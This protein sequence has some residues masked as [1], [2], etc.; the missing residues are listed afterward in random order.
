[1]HPTVRTILDAQ[2]GVASTSQ[3]QAAG[4]SRFEVRR[5]VQCGGLVRLRRGVVV[6]T[7]VWRAAASWDKHLIRARGL[8]LGP[9]G[10][11]DSPVALSHQSVLALHDIAVHGVDD[12]VHV[13]RIDGRRGQSDAFVQCHAPVAPELTQRLILADGVDTGPVR[14]VR[15]EVALLQVAA[16]FGVEAGLVSADCAVR[17]QVVSRECLAKAVTARRLGNGAANARTMVEELNPGA[18]SPGESRCRWL[19]HILGLPRPVSQAVIRDEMGA[20]VARVDFLFADQRTIVEF[21]GRVKYTDNHALFAEKEREDALRALGYSVVR[22]IWREL[23]DPGRVLLKVRRGFR[24][25]AN[26][27]H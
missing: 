20:F 26:L 25:A 27:H 1:M 21:D 15:P 18:E 7:M 23:A 5:L 10:A 19:F 11:P 9:A 2:G 24:V 22:I 3:L 4:V 6:D 12:R 13:V 17:R 14:A 8:M 16:T